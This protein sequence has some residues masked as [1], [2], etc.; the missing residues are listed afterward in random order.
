[1]G[2]ALPAGLVF[3]GL[4]LLISLLGRGVVCRFRLFVDDLNVLVAF[5]AAFV[6]GFGLVCVN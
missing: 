1:M 3:L 4:L 6:G 5:I 2:G